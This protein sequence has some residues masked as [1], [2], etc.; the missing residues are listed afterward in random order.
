MF[1]SCG[2]LGSR[3]MAINAVF[4]RQRRCQRIER[5]RGKKARKPVCSA[6]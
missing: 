3:A 1:K 6:P 4:A 5:Q 2:H